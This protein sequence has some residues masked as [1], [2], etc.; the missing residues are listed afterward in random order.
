MTFDDKVELL[1]TIEI[2]VRQDL[3][4]GEVWYLSP[5]MAEFFGVRV[6]QLQAGAAAGD[7]LYLDVRTRHRPR[8]TVK[9]TFAYDSP[10]VAQSAAAWIVANV[11]RMQ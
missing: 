1:S 10:D 6:P 5:T 11:R 4:I 3:P 9:T 7:L 2:L 8:T